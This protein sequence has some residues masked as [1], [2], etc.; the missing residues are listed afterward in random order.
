MNISKLLKGFIEPRASQRG[1]P[2]AT[3]TDQGT[4][5]RGKITLFGDRRPVITLTESADASTFMHESAHH[6]LEQLLTDAVHPLAPDGLKAD[7]A[8]VRRWLGAESNEDITYKGANENRLAA[9]T[10]RHEKFARG[11]ERYLMEGIAPSH[12]LA[13]AFA[14]YKT[15]LTD[16]YQHVDQLDAP[17]TDE[18]RS[19]FD[20]MLSIGSQQAPTD[21]PGQPPHETIIR[22]YAALLARDP[23]QVR[24]VDE[25]VLPHEKGLI[26]NTLLSEI[27]K[28][29]PQ[30]I[31][32]MLCAQA[33]FLAQYQFCV[34]P[35]P[36]E[37]FGID[38]TKFPR[39]TPK[40]LRALAE[41]VGAEAQI[42]RKQQFDNL[43]KIV[44]QELK[45]ITAKIAAAKSKRKT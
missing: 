38:I 13:P 6:W 28:G 5:I 39:T 10:E 18:V 40:E 2:P 43:N 42:K 29:H 30:Q 1:K 33:I 45:Y 11:F 24:I 3:T 26:L 44:E 8:T 35:K 7:A 15:W 20:R 17:I 27:E 16:I 36:L 37:P 21:Q 19:V 31:E 34:G 25:S 9:A 4:P 32:E 41:L 23:P 14:N 22:D 12:A